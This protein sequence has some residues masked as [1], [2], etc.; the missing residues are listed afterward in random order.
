MRKALKILVWKIR[1]SSLKDSG[2]D[3][4]FIFKWVKKQ[5]VDHINV[6]WDVVRCWD[7]VNTLMCF[8]KY[9]VRILLEALVVLNEISYGFLS[10]RICWWS[11]QIGEDRVLSIHR[12]Q[13]SLSILLAICRNR[14]TLPTF[15]RKFLS[16]SSSFTLGDVRLMSFDVN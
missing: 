16:L 12:S 3:G 10:K 1:N 5:G 14:K 15:R 7:L 2:I 11:L 6:S 8:G 13:T 4:R 9:L